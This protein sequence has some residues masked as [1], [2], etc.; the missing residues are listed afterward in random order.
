MASLQITRIFAAKLLPLERDTFVYVPDKR[1]K[2]IAGLLFTDGTIVSISFQNG[3]ELEINSL[4][5]LL[6]D[7]MNLPPSKRILS[8][9]QDIAKCRIITGSIQNIIPK[10][11]SISIYL[12]TYKNEP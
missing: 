8:W 10:P 11:Q 5:T 4:D 12:L 6:I 1:I 9:E 7:S 3:A 2:R